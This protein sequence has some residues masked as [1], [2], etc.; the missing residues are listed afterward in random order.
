M[1][2][3]LRDADTSMPMRRGR[4][5]WTCVCCRRIQWIVAS[6]QFKIPD[7]ITKKFCYLHLNKNFQSSPP[8]VV[9]DP[10]KILVKV[11]QF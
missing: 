7:P 2:S 10:D 5:P 11:K 4:C 8:P 9:V 6:E 3:D 1:V